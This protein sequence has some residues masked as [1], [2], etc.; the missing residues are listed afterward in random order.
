MGDRAAY[1]Q[2]AL[3]A[4]ADLPQTRLLAQ[5][6]IYETTAWGKTGQADF[7]NMACQLDTQFTAADFFKRNTKLLSNLLVV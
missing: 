1:L 5:S 6:S 7:L 2:K 4:L 3:E